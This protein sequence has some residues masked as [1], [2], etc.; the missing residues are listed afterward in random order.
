MSIWK[1]SIAGYSTSS[2]GACEAVNLVD[3][4]HLP[5]LHAGQNRREVAGALDGG[6][7]SDV[8]RDAHLVGDDGRN[9][10]LAQPGRTEQQ[11][12]V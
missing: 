3:E 10:R 11:H 2:T 9:R 8:N 12:M 1:S 6:T 4:Q 5:R 7:R